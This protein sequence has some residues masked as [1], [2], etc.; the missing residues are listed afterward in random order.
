MNRFD[1]AIGRLQKYGWRK[2]HLGNYRDGFCALGALR[3]Q[4]HTTALRAEEDWALRD[5]GQQL[6]LPVGPVGDV[7]G[8][9]VRY[10]DTQSTSKEDII[11]LFKTASEN[12]EALK[13]TQR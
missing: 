11:L 9:I 5:A 6:G 13:E 3:T 8:W 1:R 2:G 10:N 12:L 7:T 4:T